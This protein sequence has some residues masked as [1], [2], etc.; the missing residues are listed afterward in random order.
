MFPFDQRYQLDILTW[1][2][3]NF[4]STF[5]FAVLNLR[6]CANKSLCRFKLY[7]QTYNVKYYAKVVKKERSSQVCS[8]KTNV[9]NPLHQDD[10]PA[11]R[12]YKDQY[13]YETDPFD[14]KYIQQVAWLD[15]IIYFSHEFDVPKRSDVDQIEDLKV[16]LMLKANLYMSKFSDERPKKGEKPV[17]SLAKE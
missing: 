3:P 4:C 10:R 5:S 12:Q 13:Y 17:I 11:E 14:I 8:F 2:L 1:S 9:F 6:E 16:P 15:E 7:T